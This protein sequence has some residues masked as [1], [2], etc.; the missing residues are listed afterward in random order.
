MVYYGR[1][2]VGGDVGFDDVEDGGC[3]V[4]LGGRVR[5]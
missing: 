5:E 1:G 3:G 2:A 4:D